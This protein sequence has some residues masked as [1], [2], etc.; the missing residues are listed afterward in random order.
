MAKTAQAV[1]ETKVKDGASAGF[2]KMQTEMAKTTKQGK[3]LD[4]QFRFMRGGIG[5]V[6]H[7]I[8]DVAVQ[9]QMGQNGLLVLGQQG[10]QI[11][12]IFG[13]GGAVIGAFLAVG[14]AISMALMPKL[15]GAT[16]ALKE[17]K[18]SNKGL[19]DSFDNLSPAQQKYARLLADKKLKDY[20]EEL[21]RLNNETRERQTILETGGFF[22]KF[23]AKKDDLESLKD[24][25]ERIA[26][27]DSDTAFFEAAIKSLEE[28]I[29]GTTTAFE[30]QEAALK[31]QIDTFGMSSREIQDYEIRQQI[32]RGEL[33]LT[34]GL[35]LLFHNAELNRLEKRSEAEENAQKRASAAQ[36]KAVKEAEKALK[37]KEKTTQKFAKT[38]GDGFVNAISGAMSFKDAMKNVAQSVVND[39][40]RMI[41]QKNIT[42]RVYGFLTNIFN[43]GGGSGSEQVG[44]ASTNPYNPNMGFQSMQPRANGGLVTKGRPYM[45]GERGRELFVPNQSGNIIPNNRLESG[46]VTVNQT[47]NITTGVQATVRAEI[48]NL[49]PQIN[50]STKAAVAE[51]RQRG[52]GYS[53]ALLGV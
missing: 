12:S 3:V 24:Y 30:K 48:Q 22:D 43:P 27:L 20:R 29:D 40:I 34:E 52:G 42:D 31:K 46:G 16:E 19:I 36:Q 11:A 17:L 1:I 51:A 41:V 13:P 38:I 5:Q 32:L 25:N 53:K 4:R 6:G 8:Q 7:Q 47:I 33:E 35:Q 9:L 44:A 45:V 50:E 18:E 21:K 37:E 28:Q 49:M 2:R 14:S 39:L 26:K 15:F 10:G 23:L